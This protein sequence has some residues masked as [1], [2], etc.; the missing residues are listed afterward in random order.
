M[1][2]TFA[3]LALPLAAVVA[4]NVAA[5]VVAAPPKL[6]SPACRI[7]GAPV[8]GFATK[9]LSPKTFNALHAAM[10]PGGTGERW[11]EIG[12]QPDLVAARQTAA[13]ENKPLVL[14]IMDGH[15][16]GCT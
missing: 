14:W 10:R 3:T 16:L 11:A 15:P 7:G 13:R 1:K 4:A 2:P 6:S 9:L 5:A 8:P 12:W